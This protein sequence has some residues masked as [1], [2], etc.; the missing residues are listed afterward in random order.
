VLKIKARLAGRGHGDLQGDRH[1][2]DHSLQ[3]LQAALAIRDKA[4]FG[5]LPV[6]IGIAVGPAVV[7]QF[8][9][10]SSVTAVGET[11]NLA[12]RLQAQVREVQLSEEAYR[13]AR[14]WLREQELRATEESLTP[15]GIRPAGPRLS[16]GGTFPSARRANLGS[17]GRDPVLESDAA[18]FYVDERG[19]RIS[20]KAPASIPTP[21]SPMSTKRPA[22]T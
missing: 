3:A 15:E 6:R 16:S 12:A 17:D 8:S 20:N 13:R 9:Q 4:A 2:L 21:A 11:I 7:G 18:P 19:W 1:R 5:G 10:G 22:A 14:D